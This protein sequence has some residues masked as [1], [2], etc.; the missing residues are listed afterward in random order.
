MFQCTVAASSPEILAEPDS[1]GAGRRTDPGHVAALTGLRGLAAIIVV[2]VH[3]SSLTAHPW[4]GIHG[5][6]PI[7]LFTL[8]G[9]LLFQPWSRW[10]LAASRRPS[11]RTFARRRVWRIFPAYLVVLATV[12]L[13]YPASRPETGRQWLHAV[14]LTSIYDPEGRLPALEHTWSLGTELTW[15]VALPLLGAILAFLV[16]RGVVGGARSVLWLLA[17]ALVVTAVWRWYVGTQVE[18]AGHRVMYPAWLMSYL[19]CF[20][21]GAAIGHLVIAHRH[22]HA[23]ARWLRW[24]GARSYL[25]LAVASVAALIANSP[26]G[27]PWTFSATTLGQL[28]VRAAMCTMAALALLAG[29][30]AAPPSS[31]VPRLFATPWLEAVGRWSYGI[32]LWHMPIVILAWDEGLIGSS[33]VSFLGWM[34]MLLGI[35]VALGAA[36]YRFVERPAIAWS[37]RG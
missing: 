2:V 3:G 29:I 23:S 36:T 37:K 14:T 19:A 27:G 6:G 1:S 12:A 33:G 16:S 7:A 22:G 32:Y 17:G 26:W 10:I 5:Y 20:I 35:S 31:L 21:G 8:S 28:T 24:F 30:A 11:V 15:Y 9:F 25:V 34:A 4:L 13:V 18:D